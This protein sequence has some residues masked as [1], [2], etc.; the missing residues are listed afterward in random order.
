MSLTRLKTGTRMS[1][2]VI[3]NGTVFLCAQVGAGPTVSCRRPMP[4]QM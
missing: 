1:S 2:I 4:S 3:H